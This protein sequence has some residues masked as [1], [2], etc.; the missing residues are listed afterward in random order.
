MTRAERFHRRFLCREA[1]GEVGRRIST[2]RRVRNLSIGKDAAQKS[3]AI[4]VDRRFDAINF[5]C[6]HPDADNIC[7]HG[8]P[9][10]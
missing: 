9:T 5:G 8:L 4:T 7:G 3:I 10:A 6:V 1:A 2:P